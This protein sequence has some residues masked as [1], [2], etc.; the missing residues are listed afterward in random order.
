[1]PPPLVVTRCRQTW[2]MLIK[3]D[4]EVDPLACPK[5]GEQIKVITFIEPPQGA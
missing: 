5:C 4:Y 3:R 2:A 1:M